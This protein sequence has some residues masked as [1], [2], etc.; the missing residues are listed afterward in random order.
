[1]RPAHVLK[2]VA[3]NVVLRMYSKRWQWSWDGIYSKN[4]YWL[5]VRIYSKWV[6]PVTVCA[7]LKRWVTPLLPGG[8]AIY[9]KKQ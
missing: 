5:R 1:M 9:S 7:S 6:T 3:P 4:L 2:E 8:S